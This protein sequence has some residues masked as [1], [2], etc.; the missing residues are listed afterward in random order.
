[1]TQPQSQSPPEPQGG[2]VRGFLPEHEGRQLYEWAQQAAPIGPLLEIG[3]YCGKSTIWLGQAAK[4]HGTVVFALDHHRGS[5]EHQPGESHHDEALT[6]TA[7]QFDTFGEF[8]RNIGAAGLEDTV[9]PIV[10][11]SE[12]VGPHWQG[13]LGMVFIDGGHSLDAALTDYRAWAPHLLPG[14]ILAIHDVFPDP[15]DG[16]QAPFT[17]W[18]LATQSGLFE[19]LG[20]QDTLRGL[21]RLGR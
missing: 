11:S 6:N 19:P 5:E 10:A 9:V 21:K 14:G 7:G 12:I 18:Q 8:R 13:G 20:T 15:A 16:G 1:M 2:S 3:S 17:I 4:A